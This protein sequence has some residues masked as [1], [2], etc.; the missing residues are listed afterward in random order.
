V[1]VDFLVVGAGPTGIGAALNLA[2]RDED[3]LIVDSDHRP[4]GLA[5][6]VTDSS[7]FTWDFGGHVQF[8]HYDLFDEFMDRALGHDGWLEH[9]RESWI[10]VAGRFVPFPLQNNL[11]RLPDA[12]RAACIDGLRKLPAQRA[13]P[14]N[15]RAWIDDNFGDGIA[16]L[17][18]VPYNLKVWA[19][20]LE[21][22]GCQWVADRVAVPSLAALEQAA[23]TLD[24][25]IAWGPNSTFRFPKFGGTGAVWA[26]LASSLDASR[27]RMGDGLVRINPRIRSASLGSGLEVSYEHLISTIPLDQVTRVAGLDVLSAATS[28]LRHSS[29]NVVGIGIVGSPPASLRAKS[30]MYFPESS[31]P[32]YRVTVFSNYSPQN[33][34]SGTWSL[35]A[36]VSE[37][38]FK[39]VDHNQV[40]DTVVDG[41]LSVGLLDPRSQIAS[42]WHTVLPYGY[43]IPTISR[44]LVLAE[45]LPALDEIG[46]HSRGRFGAWKYEVSN[47]DHSFM[48]GWECVDRICTGA[49]PEVERTLSRPD[50]VNSAP[51]HRAVNR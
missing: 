15:F 6:S 46:I 27:V 42:R 28:Q 17:F 10:W 49:G 32:F 26:A 20:P 16:E 11:H 12:E 39:P 19:H 13:A 8:S 51:R 4:G 18:M 48:Q 35:M 23:H 31:S 50:E 22:M 47:Q 36:E 3:F 40:V 37:S 21:L 9:V 7:G 14:A 29:T 34:P 5:K 25:D 44:D 38:E 41:M 43:P 33:V 1:K 45:V 24:D 2:G 30:W